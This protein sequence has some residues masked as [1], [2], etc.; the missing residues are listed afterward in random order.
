MAMMDGF[1]D[2]SCSGGEYQGGSS[3]ER[4]VEIQPSLSSYRHCKCG[5]LPLT[6]LLSS[7]YLVDVSCVGDGISR[8]LVAFWGFHLASC[9]VSFAESELTDSVP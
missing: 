4:L 8:C 5:H 9:P 7:S 6:F 1:I 3:R 2:V